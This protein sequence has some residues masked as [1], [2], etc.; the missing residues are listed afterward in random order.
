MQVLSLK[1]N[2][3]RVHKAGIFPGGLL[4]LIA[5]CM[6]PS[7][8]HA[9]FRASIQGTVTDPTGAVIPG[10]T[11]TLTDITTNHQQTATTTGAAVYT[12]TLC[13]RTNSL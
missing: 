2:H 4:L 5:I 11:V 12:L 3:S 10:A 9:Q 8:A 6:V 7:V 1:Q 13:L